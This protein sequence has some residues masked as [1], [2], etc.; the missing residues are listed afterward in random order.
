MGREVSGRVVV[1]DKLLYE[2]SRRVRVRVNSTGRESS[3]REGQTIVTSWPCSD[4]LARQVRL[5][6]PRGAARHGAT[7]R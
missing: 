1:G 3:R 4:R 6:V 7:P 2:A 5:L